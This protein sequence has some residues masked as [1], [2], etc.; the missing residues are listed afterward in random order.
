MDAQS[1]ADDTISSVRDK[2]PDGGWGWFIVLS[3]H[4]SQAILDGV[5]ASIAVLL[6]RMKTY[7]NEGAMRISLIASIGLF[8]SHCSAPIAVFLSKKYGA[9]CIAVIGG[10]LCAVGLFLSG[11]VNSFAVLCLTLAVLANF[12][13]SLSFTSTFT[14]LGQYFNKRHGLAN[15]LAVAGYGIGVMGIP[16]LTQLLIYKYGWQGACIVL[17]GVIAH[18]CVAATLLRPLNTATKDNQMTEQRNNHCV[19]M[20]KRICMLF[21]FHLLWV[22]PRVIGFVVCILFLSAS[23]G[24]FLTFL[25]QRTGDAGIDPTDGALLMTVIGAS[26]CI[27]RLTHGW[28]IDLRLVP[29]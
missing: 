16:P 22:Q 25:L 28:F 4:I 8:V 26:S 1:K 12:G 13:L 18:L 15:G 14:L 19:R 27:T 21:G 10:I 24:T 7:F 2:A 9:R 17:S 20:C 5:I 6:V 23:N 29:P 3:A 11:F